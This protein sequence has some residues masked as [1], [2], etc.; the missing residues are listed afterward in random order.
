MSA[1]QTGR[2]L[3]SRLDRV[4]VQNQTDIA[5]DKA[6]NERIDRLTVTVGALPTRRDVGSLAIRINWLEAVVREETATL[7]AGFLG[8]LWWLLTGRRPRG[9]G[10][11]L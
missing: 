11:R 8:R 3:V 1:E 6:I 2:C 9:A 5:A 10:R 4:E 7:R